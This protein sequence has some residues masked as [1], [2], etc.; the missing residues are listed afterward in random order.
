[1]ADNNISKWL[2]SSLGE[3]KNK[4][5]KFIINAVT[6]HIAEIFKFPVDEKTGLN[7]ETI[8]IHIKPGISKDANSPACFHSAPNINGKTTEPKGIITTAGMDIIAD[9]IRVNFIK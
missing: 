1:M 5:I 8:K 4:R 9:K 3:K 7:V 6:F 2:I